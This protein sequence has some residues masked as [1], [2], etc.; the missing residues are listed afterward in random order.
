VMPDLVPLEHRQCARI[1]CSAQ[2]R[3][4]CLCG[5]AVDGSHHF[6][7]ELT[8]SSRVERHVRRFSLSFRI[9]ELPATIQSVSHEHRKLHLTA[10]WCVWTL[11]GTTKAPTGAVFQANLG[12]K[13]CTWR[14][15]E[16]K[17]CPDGINSP[18]E[19]IQRRSTF[20]P[21]CTILLSCPSAS[22]LPD[23]A[24]GGT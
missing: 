9:C 21:T 8:G 23:L 20:S 17:V 2:P 7:Q 13:R 5:Q 16:A 14:S 15:P 24:R 19:K 12:V 11:P 1:A 6:A 3:P 18:P 10:C 4:A 22:L